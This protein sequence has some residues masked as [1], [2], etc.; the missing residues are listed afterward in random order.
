MRWKWI[1]AGLALLPALASAGS[2]PPQVQ[3]NI[4]IIQPLTG[5]TATSSIST[6]GLPIFQYISDGLA[7]LHEVAVGIVILW[8]LFAGF[9]YMISGNDQS[10][11]SQAKDHVVAAIIGLLMLFLLGFIL[12]V[13]NASFFIQ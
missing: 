3:G 8:L 13:L 11:R 4:N 5:G 7:W 1:S 2:A 12:S 10:K 6:S 9:S